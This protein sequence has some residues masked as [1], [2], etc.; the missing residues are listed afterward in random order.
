MASLLFARAVSLLTAHPNLVPPQLQR[1]WEARK[2]QFHAWLESSSNGLFWV[3]PALPGDLPPV[4][5]IQ[6]RVRPA[7]EPPQ[8]Y[9]RYWSNHTLHAVAAAAQAVF[10]RHLVVE[11]SSQRP[12]HAAAEVLVY[13]VTSVLVGAHGAGAVF[14][15]T[16][17]HAQR[18]VYSITIL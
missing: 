7:S 11:M 14:L 10:P 12:L 9:A 1:H 17:V 8:Q 4:L 3:P 5:T 6:Q 16:V 13:S 18:I 2:A 15:Y